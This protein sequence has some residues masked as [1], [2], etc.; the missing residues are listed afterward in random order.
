[1]QDGTSPLSVPKFARGHLLS[2]L[3]G[4]D[5]GWCA[6]SDTNTVVFAMSGETQAKVIT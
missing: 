3:P 5:N 1:M 4:G 2:T 6:A